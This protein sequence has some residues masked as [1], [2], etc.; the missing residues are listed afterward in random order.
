MRVLIVSHHAPPMASTGTLR[1][2]SFARYFADRGD[3]VTILTTEKREDQRGGDA[4]PEGVCVEEVPFNPPRA[5]ER[6]RRSNGVGGGVDA[7]APSLLRRFRE[8][9]GIF[10]SA[11]APD[12]TGSWIAPAARRAE[13]IA[14]AGGWDLLLSSSGPYTANLVAERIADADLARV[15]IADFRDLWTANPVFGGLPLVRSWERRAERRVLRKADAIT[16]VAEPLCAWFRAQGCA[17]VV[18]IRNGY[19]PSATIAQEPAFERTEALDLVYTG[20]VY[21]Q[22]ADPRTIFEAAR[23]IERPVRVH[24]AGD[25]GHIWRDA[26]SA[27]AGKDEL[28]LHGMLPRDRVLAMQR[29]AGVVLALGANGPGY[30]AIPV[31]LLDALPMAAPVLLIGGPV[32]A[33]AAELLRDAGRGRHVEERP[34]AIARFLAAPPLLEPNPAVV[35]A[36]A[37]TAQASRLADLADELLKNG[38]APRS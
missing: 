20:T 8:R 15:W 32:Y 31:K 5:L 26:A 17:K 38:T 22:Q 25:R 19:D 6:L 21:P 23:E 34:D 24:V 27:K 30:G 33:P 16:T 36:H 13:L 18:E 9:T 35:R 12:L 7:S 4:A 3:E 14:P 10:G 28:I 1:V 11:R 29:D 2:A 37:R